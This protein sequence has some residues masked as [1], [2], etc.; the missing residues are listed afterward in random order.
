[1]SVHNGESELRI[2]LTAL[3]LLVIE[4]ENK[5]AGAPLPKIP[6]SR[7]V[8]YLLRSIVFNPYTANGSATKPEMPMRK[9]AN[10]IAVKPV[11]DFFINIYEVPQITVS[12]ASRIQF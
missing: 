5:K 10:S 3:P 4:S 12:S 6:I 11:S 8:K 7:M 9:H 2:P 1:M